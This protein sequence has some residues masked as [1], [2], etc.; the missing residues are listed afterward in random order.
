MCA[1]CVCAVCVYVCVTLAKEQLFHCDSHGYRSANVANKKSHKFKTAELFCATNP[2]QTQYTVNNNKGLWLTFC[3]E[4][5]FDSCVCGD[6]YHDDLCV[7]WETACGAE[8]GGTRGREMSIEGSE[9][10]VT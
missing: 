3:E 10:S 4:I 2:K 5:C 1:V 7:D 9:A 8:E 6:P